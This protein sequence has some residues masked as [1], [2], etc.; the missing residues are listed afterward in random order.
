MTEN[1]DAADFHIGFRVFYC[2]SYAPLIFGSIYNIVTS[3]PNKKNRN[4]LL[5]L[6]VLALLTSLVL[7]IAQAFLISDLAQFPVSEYGLEYTMTTIY[8]HYVVLQ[9]MSFAFIN[10]L[11]VQVLFMWIELFNSVKYGN[12][13]E[14]AKVQRRYIFIRN[15]FSFM[16]FCLFLIPM[17]VAFFQDPAKFLTSLEIIYGILAVFILPVLVLSVIRWNSLYKIMKTCLATSTRNG[18]KFLDLTKA[19]VL[20]IIVYIL[21]QLFLSAPSNINTG[22]IQFYFF[23]SWIP[24]WLMPAIITWYFSPL[25]QKRHKSPLTSPGPSGGPPD[26]Q[27]PESNSVDV[28]SIEVTKGVLPEVDIIVVDGSQITTE[29]H[30]GK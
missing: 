14:Q 18:N 5:T 15:G 22:S 23:C 13:V 27:N 30:E 2:V 17:E 3:V 28:V 10:T 4:V 21:N 11:L 20:T 24:N 19:T 26:S 25:W 12:F 29:P 7:M 1:T 8:V 16:V 6:H 9:I